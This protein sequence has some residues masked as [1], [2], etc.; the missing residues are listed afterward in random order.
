MSR[1]KKI[2]ISA[3]IIFNFLSMIRVHVPMETKFFSA[4]YIPVDTYLSFFSIYQ[5]WL[6]FAKNPSR[7][8][9]YLTADIEF[10]DGSVETY[11]FPNSKDLNH[12]DKYKFGE[13]YRKIISEGIVSTNKK[14]L[15]KDAARF[16]L[17]KMKDSQFTR[18]PKR[19]FLKK[20]TFEIPEWKEQF[21]PHNSRN[22]TYQ[23]KIFYTHEVI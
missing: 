1:G 13:R 9:S 15:W 17:R 2:V 7:T 11:K 23:S 16:S 18:I 3:F 22:K 4:I 10:I 5:D 21:L 14:F 19:V 20:H 6:M 12:F 8:N